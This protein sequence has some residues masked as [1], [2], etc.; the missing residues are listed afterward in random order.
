MRLLLQV[1]G[2]LW[3][4]SLYLHNIQ[5]LQLPI[6]KLATRDPRPIGCHTLDVS[7]YAKYS[8]SNTATVH[9]LTTCGGNFFK[10]LE[11]YDK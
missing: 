5:G 1:T 11:K 8:Q 2:R 9:V 3:N 4:P 7:T 10:S 6:Y